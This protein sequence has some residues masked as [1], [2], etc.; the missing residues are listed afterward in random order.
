MAATSQSAPQKKV[1]AAQPKLRL[2]YGR[3]SVALVGLLALVATLVTA[4]LAPFTSIGFG[5]VFFLFALGVASF[6]ALRTMAVRDRNRKLL[7]RM[8]AVR[9]QALH[10]PAFEDSSNQVIAKSAKDEK[11]FD[12]RPDSGRRAPS[13][14][15]EELRAEALRVA[16][17]DGGVKQPATWEPTEVPK[18]KYVAVR[19]ATEATRQQV[20]EQVRPEPLPKAEPLRPSAKIS[21]KASEEAREIAKQVSAAD[22]AAIAKLDAARGTGEEKAAETPVKPAA[23]EEAAKAA[24]AKAEKAAPAPKAKTEAEGSK[25]RLNLDAVLQRRRA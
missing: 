9:E 25:Q 15:A 8:E 6:A 7:Q 18:P 23:S 11:V 14:T 24:P 3:L 21:L 13:I 4:V 5:L 17:G 12:A 20:A 10:T 22:K 1:S 2:R 19:E 16:R